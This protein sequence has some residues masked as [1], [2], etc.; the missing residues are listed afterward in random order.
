MEIYLIIV[1]EITLLLQY[2]TL[3]L[4]NS[5]S[6]AESSEE[7]RIFAVETDR[8]EGNKGINE[9]FND[10]IIPEPKA[11]FHS[12]MNIKG[13]ENEEAQSKIEQKGMYL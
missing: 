13:F 5:N 12:R 3:D 4:R 1:W 11:S 2:T 8:H 9:K 6:I 10:R 7:D